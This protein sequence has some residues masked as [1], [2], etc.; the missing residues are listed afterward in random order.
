VFGEKSEAI[1]ALGARTFA[2]LQLLVPVVTHW[3]A[4]MH[5]GSP[6]YPECILQEG[7]EDEGD[8]LEERSL[9]YFIRAAIVLLRMN[10][11]RIQ[12]EP[13]CRPRVVRDI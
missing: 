13:G 4:P 1:L 11:A 6:D 2:D 5:L 12:C 3:N 8:G 9:A 10:D 7:G